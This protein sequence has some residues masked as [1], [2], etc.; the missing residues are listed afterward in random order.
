MPP[1]HATPVPAMDDRTKR[2]FRLWAIL[3]ALWVAGCAG[4]ALF[5]AFPPTVCWTIIAVAPAPDAPDDAKAEAAGLNTALPKQTLCRSGD[6]PDMAALEAL[7]GAGRIARVA[8]RLPE[9]R[10]WSPDLTSE[11]AI[12][13]GPQVSRT[14][15]ASRAAQ[16]WRGAWLAKWAQPL[17]A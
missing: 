17:A 14:A 12:I 1:W 8:V 4:L 3:S 2:L 6:A 15:I 13:P 5:N 10:G 9:P 11:T 7:A 16:H